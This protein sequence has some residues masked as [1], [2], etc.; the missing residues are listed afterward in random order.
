M[1]LR[2]VFLL[3]GGAYWHL[4]SRDPDGTP[5]HLKN[6]ELHCPITW[7]C[8]GPAAEAAPPLAADMTSTTAAAVMEAMART[9]RGQ[10]P[11]SPPPQLGRFVGKKTSGVR[12]DKT[13]IP[14]AA[15]VI[16]VDPLMITLKR[17]ANAKEADNRL[18]AATG[19]TKG[20]NSRSTTRSKVD[21][22]LLAKVGSSLSASTTADDSQS[23]TKMDSGLSRRLAEKD[24]RLANS[25]SS[26]KADSAL[27]SVQMLREIELKKT[28]GE[29]MDG[30]LEMGKPVLK[31]L[32]QSFKKR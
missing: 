5:A 7:L 16:S 15:A 3:Q 26:A 20:V 19:S 13:T 27:S 22:W 11:L 18:S 10:P 31:D 21:S 6:T 8:V 9:A 25:A 14:A 32:L 17:S 23:T 28:M 2:V 29:N 12:T 24:D 4:P 30:K 1:D